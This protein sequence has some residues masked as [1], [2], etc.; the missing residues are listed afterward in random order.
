MVYLNL[1][2]PS[3]V[4][5]N[6]NSL[7]N[8]HEALIMQNQNHD[9]NTLNAVNT[10]CKSYPKTN[11]LKEFN[12]SLRGELDE[13]LKE[14]IKYYQAREHLNDIE[15]I[16][17]VIRHGLIRCYRMNYLLVKHHLFKISEI[18]RDV[19]IYDDAIFI[20]EEKEDLIN[21]DII[22]Y[23]KFWIKNEYHNPFKE[24]Q[25]NVKEPEIEDLLSLSLT[26]S[27]IL[28]QEVED[29]M[30]VFH[31]EYNYSPEKSLEHMLQVGI[32]NAF[33]LVGK[34]CSTAELIENDIFAYDN[35]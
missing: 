16:E 33:K 25:F 35:E 1:D 18:D 12:L 6:N 27:G 11:E 14:I 26:I 34:G 32:N 8:N 30:S 17:I 19:D 4:T 13:K 5:T 9:F 22:K 2:T 29:C 24:K 21:T 10:Y 31:Q 23:E 7:N 3:G 20:V 28:L 15:I